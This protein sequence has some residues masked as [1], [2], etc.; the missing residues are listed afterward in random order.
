MRHAERLRFR[1]HGFGGVEGVVFAGVLPEHLV[2]PRFSLAQHRAADFPL[3]FDHGDMAT[4]MIS[5][6]EL[7][8]EALIKCFLTFALVAIM[9]RVNSM[10]HFDTLL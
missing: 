9:D 5:I 1:A 10:R 2:V 7:I 6:G 8:L 3:H 4:A